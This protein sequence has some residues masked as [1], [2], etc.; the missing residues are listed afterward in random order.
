ML[1]LLSFAMDAQ[2]FDPKV[3]DRRPLVECSP[4][5]GA[6]NFFGKLESGQPEVTIAYFGGSITAQEGYRVYSRNYLQSLF[7]ET[8]INEVNAAIGGTATDLG[9]FRCWHDVTREHPDLVFVEF[10][11]NDSGLPVIET[12]K[13]TEG[14]IR[15]IWNA[16][17]ETDIILVYTLTAGNMDV[18]REGYMQRSACVMEDLADW[19]GIPS[20]H[21]G[22]EIARLDKLGLIEMKSELGK[23]TKVSADG[24]GVLI[25]SPG[26]NEDGKICVNDEGKIPFSKD[27]VHPYVITGHA[28]YMGSLMRS[29]PF[30]SGAGFKGPHVMPEPM[31]AERIEQV[32]TVSFEDPRIR[33]SGEWCKMSRDDR[34]VDQFLNRCDDFYRFSPG[35]EISFRFKGSKASIYDILGQGCGQVT[36]SVDGGEP[37]AAK[38]IDGYCTYYRLALLD[39]CKGLD[40]E[41]V[42]TV[43][44]RVSEEKF[45][46][47]SI[48]FE[49]NRSFYDENRQMYED[50]WDF[51]AGCVFIAGEIVE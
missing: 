32:A 35:A 47:R 33:K 11:V 2:S 1:T 13:N 17:P 4:R 40:P 5:G 26:I 30:I 14:I 3:V 25:Q 19:Y 36:I 16:D 22:A 50:S 28:L 49:N 45:D 21:F 39:L 38:R 23:K 10:A 48:L 27:G 15:Q 42:H 43:T 6:P 8:K 34:T 12:R 20:V 44:I 51:L 46:K 24:L 7:P 9:V 31:L 37:V 41:Q 29:F 18:I